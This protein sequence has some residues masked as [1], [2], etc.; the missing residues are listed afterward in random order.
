MVSRELAHDDR[1]SLDVVQGMGAF[2][3]SNVAHMG[4][5]HLPGLPPTTRLGAMERRRSSWLA[6]L[7]HP[8]VPQEMSWPTADVMRL[9]DA[10]VVAEGGPDAMVRAVRVSVPS[11]KDLRE[12]REI[13]ANTI[14]HALWDY[15]VGTNPGFRENF[16]RFLG[17]RWAPLEAA[18]DPT[19]LNHFWVDNVLKSFGH[20]RR[21]A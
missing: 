15:A 1:E 19:H 4:A 7:F 11:C 17:A 12:A 18:N 14:A 2:T 3:D 13:A 10:M 8:R 20:Q 5:G 21:T 9:I 16:V 6:F